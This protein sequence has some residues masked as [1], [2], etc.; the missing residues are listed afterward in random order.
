M[1]RVRI[2]NTFRVIRMELHLR[3]AD[4]AARAGVSQQTVSS[5]ER[6]RFG[7]LSVDVLDQVAQVLQADLAVALRWRG[8]KLARLLDRRHA[9]LENQVVAALAAAG[10]EVVPEESFNRFGERGSVDVLGWHAESRALAIIEIKTEI[11]DLQELLRVLDMKARVV[12]R[13]VSETRNW[14]PTG[15]AA[16]VVLP[17]S[18]AQRRSVASHAALLDAA[19]P[20]RTREV[21]RWLERPV[22]GLRGIWFFPCTPGQSV[23]EQLRASRRVRLARKGAPRPKSTPAGAQR[24]PNRPAT[25]PQVTDSVRSRP[26]NAAQAAFGERPAVLDPDPLP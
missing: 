6:G 18:N 7:A 26:R 13:V 9:W 21:G 24:C 2:G 11:V 22:G 1:D 15:V 3:Q 19:L 17:S 10:W 5:I 25:W 14:R 4:V 16:V 23:M 8:S 20:A 12:P